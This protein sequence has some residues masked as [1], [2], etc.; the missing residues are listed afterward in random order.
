MSSDLVA[1]R[2]LLTADDPSWLRATATRHGGVVSEEVLTSYPGQ[3][4][5]LF[6]NSAAAAAFATDLRADGRYGCVE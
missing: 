2:V 5:V 4:D 6:P 3:Q 1:V